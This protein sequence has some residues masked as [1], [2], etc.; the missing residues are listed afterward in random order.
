MNQKSKIAIGTCL[1]A[2]LAWY[3]ASPWMALRQMKSAIERRDAAAVSEHI[4]FPAL[5]ENVKAELTTAM[6]AEASRR[7]VQNPL[8]AA[9]SALALAFAGPMLDAMISPQGVAMMLKGKDEGLVPEA[10]RGKSSKDVDITRTYTGLNTFEVRLTSRQNADNGITL[11]F[12]RHGFANWMLTSAQ[13][14][15]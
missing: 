12:K 14:P 8:S 1:A 9:G 11:V 7:R 2:A 4:D 3:L 15:M 6:M 5:R 10:F 13:F